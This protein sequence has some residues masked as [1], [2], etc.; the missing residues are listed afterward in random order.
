MIAAR[1]GSPSGAAPGAAVIGGG[2]QLCRPLGVGKVGGGNA[3]LCAA[4]LLVAGV[5]SVFAYVVI[6]GSKDDSKQIVETFTP[7]KVDVEVACETNT[8]GDHVFTVKNIGNV[9]A[10]VRVAIVCNWIDKD[11]GNV[12]WGKPE[13]TDCL[14][15]SSWKPA[16]D[17]YYYYLSPVKSGDTVDAVITVKDPT[18]NSIAVAPDGYAFSVTVLAEGIQAVGENVGAVPAID[19]V[20][21]GNELTFTINTPNK[22]LTIAPKTTS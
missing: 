6:D 19:D 11:D 17:E 9:D 16:T 15:H 13:M 7:G 14:E 2:Q 10:Y 22:D 12:Y 18:K 8:D 20:W 4:L 21:G 3:L 5:G 1:T